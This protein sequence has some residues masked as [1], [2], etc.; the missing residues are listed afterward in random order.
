MSGIDERKNVMSLK[1]CSKCGRGVFTWLIKSSVRQVPPPFFN[2][3]DTWGGPDYVLDGPFESIEYFK[4]KKCQHKFRR[5]SVM[6]R[7][8]INVMKAS[9]HVSNNPNRAGDRNERTR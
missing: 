4:C 1:T 5:G 9:P 8:L 7:L 2:C 6:Y 3:T